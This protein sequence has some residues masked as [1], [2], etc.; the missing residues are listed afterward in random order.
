MKKK[1][2][3]AKYTVGIS[4]SS[5]NS[6][7]GRANAYGYDQ[8]TGLAGI[9]EFQTIAPQFLDEIFARRKNPVVT[10]LDLAGM[11]S[12]NIRYGFDEGDRLLIAFANILANKFGKDRCCRFANDQFAVISTSDNIEAELKK[13]FSQLE[14]ANSRKTLKVSA[15]IYAVPDSSENIAYSVDR[16]KMAADVNKVSVESK[17]T[18]FN[19]KMGSDYLLKSYIISHIDQA[20][21]R[22]WIRVYLQ[23][24]VRVL[25]EKL[26]SFEA[27]ARWEDPTYGLL[28]PG[29]FISVL[30][31][32]G[33][34]YKLDMEIVRRTAMLQRARLDAGKAVLPVSVNFSRNDF[35]VGDP[36]A[37]IERI[38]KEYELPPDLFYVEITESAVIKDSALMR[39]MIERFHDIGIDVWM[40]DYGA[41]YSSLNVLKDFNFNEIKIDMEFLRNLNERSKIIISQTVQMAKKLGIHTLAEGVE[42]REQLEFLR[43]I[44][45]EKIQGYYYGK[46]LA[47][48]ELE[49]YLESRGLYD[50]NRE[51]A[52][53]YDQ[54]G[55][56]EISSEKPTAMFLY[57]KDKIFRLL[58]EN[59]A[60]KKSITSEDVTDAEAIEINMNLPDSALGKKFR[61]LAQNAIESG[62]EAKMTFVA[63]D[64]YFL[65][66]FELIAQDRTNSLL[67]AHI[68]GTD[69]DYGIKNSV[70]FDT[71]LRNLISIYDSI[72]LIDF[73]KDTRTVISSNLASEKKGDI[74]CGLKDFYANYSL[75]HIFPDD[76]ERWRNFM[77]R[78]FLIKE[79]NRFKR[80]YYE[81][82]FRIKKPDGNYEWNDFIFVALP[83]TDNNL[84]LECVKVSSIENQT[85]VD[86]AINRLLGNDDSPGTRSAIEKDALLWRTLMS[87]SYLKF[88]WKDSKRRFV[89]A[90]RSF[91]DYYNF[92]S[93]NVIKG[94]TD[95]DIGW[96][97]NNVPYR[98]DEF[99]VLTKGQ[100]IRNS[101]VECVVDGVLKPISATKFPV[102]R[103]GKIVG[104][105]GYFVDLEK[106]TAKYNL[107]AD[108]SFV[109][110]VT[111]FMNIRGL[112]LAIIQMDSELRDYNQDYTLIACEVP[113]LNDLKKEFGISF[114]KKVVARVSEKIN[115]VFSSTSTVGRYQ[116]SCFLICYRGRDD[117]LSK[118]IENLGHEIHA[119]KSV[120]S[121]K[122]TLSAVF[123]VAKGSEGASAQ[124]VVELAFERMHSGEHRK[125]QKARYLPDIYI[126]LPLPYIL[127]YPVIKGTKVIDLDFLYV[128]SK[129]CEIS[130]KNADE[131]IGHSFTE[132]FPDAD[133]NWMQ[134][135]YRSCFGEVTSGRV[136]EASIH[137]WLQF[138][139]APSSKVGCC[140]MVFMIIDEDKKTLDNLTRGKT[141]DD[142]IIRVARTLN[143]E[144][145]EKIA[146]NNTL[147]YLG[148]VI[149]S[150]RILV[151]DIE[152][153]SV[154]VKFQW[155]RDKR[156]EVSSRFET[157]DYGVI[158]YWEK[159]LLHDSSVVVYDIGVVSEFN[160][161][162][163][164]LLEKFQVVNFIATPIYND[165]KL[166]GYLVAEN[167]KIDELVDIRR[168]F[169]TV[170]YF[171]ADRKTIT[172]TLGKLQ[173]LSSHDTLTGAGNRNALFEK[174]SELK[175]I[176]SMAGV[177]F[178]DLN[179][180][181]AIN[182]SFGHSAG[183]EAIRK[184]ANLMF[185]YF[186]ESN[187]F[188]NGGDE[189]VGLL[190][191]INLA[192]FEHIRDSFTE[193]LK[194][195]GAV[196]VA[197]GFAWC[198]DTRKLEDA[199]H[200]ADKNMYAN[201]AEY[202]KHNDRR[203]KR[204]E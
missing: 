96:H 149:H 199:M 116:G 109:D 160:P 184:A 42:N 102:Y 73:K 21:E 68:D 173:R 148:Q 185:D 58:Y 54:A 131:L 142:C 182:D 30:E 118:L 129:Y 23:P 152:G 70:I 31:N 181:K 44:G 75:R 5:I 45:C 89:G 177:V 37:G 130:G 74:L 175:K 97:V 90:S 6:Q 63:R 183:D 191:N 24:V 112:M 64:H 123:G 67:L 78:D 161:D 53:F 197:A 36:V 26:C 134:F 140:S 157:F 65:F 169:E 72:Y 144:S 193:S 20:I 143:S 22:G 137:H 170:S 180:L 163:S 171:V 91:L 18:W 135:T 141:T 176:S 94:K 174:I 14:R 155:A 172:R 115:A 178:A 2:P 156:L 77:T 188:R 34:S 200:Q 196:Q 203:S 80:G 86:E 204:Q 145:D 66:S 1:A 17:Y 168:L 15:G 106:E 25:T 190:P 98:E 52:S 121:H 38:L 47:P 167:F 158:S 111:G 93:I 51:T 48:D 128:N 136:Y 103:N 162:L 126:D 13:V 28:Q 99:N 114:S 150:D 166:T 198:E 107:A 79:I 122:C 33:L 4:G 71:T 186:G 39:S 127:I 117:V 110:S 85:N 189:F 3:Q 132:V 125:V 8:L 27:L 187:V 124:K 120:A 57:G 138:Y 62:G 60:Y 35:S 100:I 83:E 46:P 50:E 92:S 61:S 82:A 147:G 32:N 146:M 40:D 11:K 192:T 133:S 59:D 43:R 10:F 16:A 179:G 154:H 95:D 119:I 165:G 9:R 151:F 87:Q 104:L 84:L 201:K 139:C 12:F 7:D 164:R 41:G 69:Y 19:E 159:L 76:L 195:S 194:N 153:W 49:E 202:Y 88:F 81:D 105:M 55:L 56:V 108:K 29:K 101:E 113:M